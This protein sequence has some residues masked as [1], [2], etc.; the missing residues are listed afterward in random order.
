M[1]D[2]L[3]FKTI[4]WGS[5]LLRTIIIVQARMNSTRLPGKI[6]K[7]IMGKPLLEYQIQRLKRVR[8]ADDVVIATTV[9]KADDLI[10][11]LC[12]NLGCK[13]FRGSEN[14]VLLRYV[15]SAKKFNADLIVRINSDCPLIDP[16][17]VERIIDYFLSDL[18][19]YD[20]VSNI[21]EVGYPIGF[22]TEVFSIGAIMKANNNS[23]N[24]LEREH[25]TPYIYRNP[26]LFNL[27]SITLDH[28]LSE[29]RLTVDYPEDFLL[30]KN[31]IEVLYPIKPNF[32]MDDIILFLE[33][34]PDIKNINKGIQKLQT[35]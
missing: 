10:V 4:N 31:V 28:D 12:K 2:G 29:Y 20:Y 25:V 34:H 32:D 14:D 17:V 5:K 27:A 30:I 26:N 11:D 9:N 23:T 33:E 3:Q 15:E 7:K 13:F 24:N 19:N 8:N 1:V 35:V 16:L 22:H 18:N 21:L 6:L